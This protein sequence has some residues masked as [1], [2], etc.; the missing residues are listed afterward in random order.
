MDKSFKTPRCPLFRG[1]PVLKGEPLAT[2]GYDS[3]KW[4]LNL[5]KIF[6][7]QMT[8]RKSTQIS[9][10]ALK[11]ARMSINQPIGA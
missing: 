8:E 9:L 4:W 7:K 10:N 5:N 3:G 11:W 1:F 2:Q 6:S